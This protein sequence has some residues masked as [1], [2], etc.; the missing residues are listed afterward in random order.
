MWETEEIAKKIKKRHK[1]GCLFCCHNVSS[2]SLFTR[3]HHDGEGTR[4]QADYRDSIM[5]SKEKIKLN[6]TPLDGKKGEVVNNEKTIYVFIKK[7]FGFKLILALK[8]L[9]F[10]ALLFFLIFS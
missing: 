7:D 2:I 5:I 4:Y 1:T 6:K 8:N 3:T 9:N 10:F